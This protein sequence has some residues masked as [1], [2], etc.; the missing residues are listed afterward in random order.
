MPS[1]FGVLRSYQIR[2]KLHIF[3]AWQIHKA[4]MVQMPTGTGNTHR[5]LRNLLC[6]DV[7]TINRKNAKGGFW[8]DKRTPF[9]R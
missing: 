1:T 5:Y 4:L 7:Q 2:I 3:D 8:V 6:L 9:A